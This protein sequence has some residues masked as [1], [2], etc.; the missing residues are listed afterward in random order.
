VSDAKQVQGEMASSLK[1]DMG[2]DADGMVISVNAKTVRLSGNVPS[3]D[4]RAKAIQIAQS[5]A[6]DRQVDTSEPRVK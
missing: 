5:K 2:N 1:N 3:S 6:G 4:D